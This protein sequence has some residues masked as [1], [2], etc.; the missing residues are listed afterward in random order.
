MREAAA[1]RGYSAGEGD[2]GGDVAARSGG[3]DAPALSVDDLDVGAHPRRRKLELRIRCST[4]SADFSSAMISGSGPS[5]S[6]NTGSPRHRQTS[7]VPPSGTITVA[8][9]G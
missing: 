3:R 5:K 1:A 2:A 4:T 7:G 8:S 9:L 6:V